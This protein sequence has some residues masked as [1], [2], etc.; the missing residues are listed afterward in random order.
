MKFN[1]LCALMM[2]LTCFETPLNIIIQ[3][4]ISEDERPLSN[5][6]ILSLRTAYRHILALRTANCLTKTHVTFWRFHLLKQDK[7]YMLW[8]EEA[9]NTLVNVCFVAFALYFSI[10]ELP[11]PCLVI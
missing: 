8:Q 1:Y 9:Q 5:C 10:V 4:S 2:L 11:S 6:Y 3:L 7:N